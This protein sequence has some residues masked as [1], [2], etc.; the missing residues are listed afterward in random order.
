MSRGDYDDYG[1]RRRDDD[2]DRDRRRDDDYDRRRRDDYDDRDRR[3]RRDY[4]DYDRGR[5]G[6]P[7]IDNYLVFSILVTLFC[8]WPFGIV[9]IIYAAGVNSYVARGDVRGARE[10]SD[11]A[12]M[13]CWISFWLGLV[14][15]IIAGIWLLF[16]AAVASNY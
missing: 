14:P 7:F 6:M 4:D 10:A 5:R 8:C 15:I 11:T 2:D 13:W 1:Y 12:K 9:A 16:V 3:P